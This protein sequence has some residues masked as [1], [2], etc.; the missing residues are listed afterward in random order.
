VTMSPGDL[1]AAM[2]IYLGAGPN[3]GYEP[4]RGDTRLEAAFGGA[5][6]EVKATLDAYLTTMMRWD[7]DWQR[8]TLGEAA[9]RIERQLAER[10]PESAPITR[11][12]MSNYFTYQWK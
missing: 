10:M 12:A 1:D 5:W 9:D 2:A 8:E 4:I 7:T 3:G 6:R 11:R